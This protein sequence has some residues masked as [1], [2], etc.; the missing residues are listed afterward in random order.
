MR[1][2]LLVCTGNTC[3]SPMAEAMLKSLAEQ[4]GIPLEV[5]SAGVSTIDGMPI[6]P[7]AAQALIN[8]Q[9]PLPGGSTSLDGETA[10]WADL[11][12][13]MT[14]G[15]KRT[16]VA[17]YP[18]ASGKTYTLKEFAMGGEPAA[19]N[20]LA[21][22]QR[23]YADWQVRQAL[24]ESLPEADR[25]RLEELASRLPDLDIADPYGGTPEMYERSADEIWEALDQ[26]VRRLNTD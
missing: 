13:T 4:G 19:M 12:L 21:E 9:L 15:H 17:R 14:T 11:I 7:H 16:V 20:D 25:K 1:R 8:R 3:R 6:S 23:L 24:G 10:R 22:A 26:V 2:I 18:E 5:R